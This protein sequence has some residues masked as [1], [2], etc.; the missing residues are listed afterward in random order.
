MTHPDST[1]REA[2]RASF[3]AIAAI[4]R[5]VGSRVVT[6]CTG[7]LDAQDQWRRHPGNDSSE[8]W[9]EMV[10]EFA[11]LV[12]IAEKHGVLIGV[13]PELANVVS[14][15]AR[16]RKLLSLFPS[17]PLRIV[18]DPANLFERGEGADV[19]PA[20]REAIERLGRDVVMAHAKDRRADG[21][22]AAPG[23]G[24]VDFAAFLSGL[25]REGFDGAVVTHGIAAQEAPECAR[26]LKQAMPMSRVR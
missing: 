7:S 1:K 23:K 22:V 26:Y 2:G 15:P 17:G 13:E 20:I 11:L 21:D 4:A 9:R 19:Q 5:R 10:A 18:L 14:T 8:A 24:V 6:V 16:A 12:S 25:Q 3:E